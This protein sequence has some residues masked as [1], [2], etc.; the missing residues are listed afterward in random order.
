VLI[1]LEKSLDFRETI[2][3]TCWKR[4]VGFFSAF[5]ERAMNGLGFLALLSFKAF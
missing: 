5:E 4:A 3:S 2:L 1:I